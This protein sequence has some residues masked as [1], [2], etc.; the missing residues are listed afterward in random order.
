V[1]NSVQPQ[2]DGPLQV[3]GDLELA[4]RDGGLRE[5]H[6][7][8]WLC[9]CGHSGTKPFCDGSHEKAGFK[10]AARVAADYRPKV[11]DTVPDA[12]RVRLSIA[13]KPDGPLR[14][15]GEMQVLEAG[16]AVAWAGRQANFC[17]CGA[18]KNKPFCDGTHRD[19]G[20]AAP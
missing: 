16:G 1:T 10:D 19:I 8:L 4:G 15:L 2:V 7:A 12:G 13:P 14:C 6:T 3:S 17:R 9:R 20:F 11:I 18:S 5:E